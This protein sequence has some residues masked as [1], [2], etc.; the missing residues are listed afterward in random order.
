MPCWLAPEL[1]HRSPCVLP[2]PASHTP[3]PRQDGAPGTAPG[4]VRVA[5]ALLALLLALWV[6]PGEVA[7]FS[8]SYFPSSIC[9]V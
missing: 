1:K 3:G 2:T 8:G 9:L 4:G 6:T 5:R 7:H